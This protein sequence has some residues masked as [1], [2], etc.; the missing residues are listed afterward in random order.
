MNTAPALIAARILWG[1]PTISSARSMPWPSARNVRYVGALSRNEDRAPVAQKKCQRAR[2]QFIAARPQELER[3]N[4]RHEDPEEQ[5]ADL[6][7]RVRCELVPLAHRA[8]RPP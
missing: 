8:R 6:D 3:G 4:H 7:H 1:T 5:D 2:A